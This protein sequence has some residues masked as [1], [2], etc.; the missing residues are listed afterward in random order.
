MENSGPTVKC[1][2]NSFWYLNN[3][4]LKIGKVKEIDRRDVNLSQPVKEIDRRDV[5]LSIS[6][7]ILTS[8][9]V[10]ERV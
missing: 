1:K 5:N 7:I 6:S 2:S 4:F 10:T 8:I 9:F 3:F